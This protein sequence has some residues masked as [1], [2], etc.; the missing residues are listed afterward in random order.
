MGRIPPTTSLNALPGNLL[1]CSI[2]LLILFSLTRQ[3]YERL[4]SDLGYRRKRGA[5]CPE[6]KLP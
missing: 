1:T 4:D 3:R 6:W 5:R 2:A